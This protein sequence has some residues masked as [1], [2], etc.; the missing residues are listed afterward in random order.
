MS[1]ITCED[2]AVYCANQ[3]SELTG[4]PLEYMFRANFRAKLKPP[5]G[6]WHSS[7]KLAGTP[8]RQTINFAGLA[9]EQ[10]KPALRRPLPS[11]RLRHRELWK[12]A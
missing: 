8:W 12:P 10:H 7:A 6:A 9:G 3:S 4:N 2:L 11:E 5:E 1:V